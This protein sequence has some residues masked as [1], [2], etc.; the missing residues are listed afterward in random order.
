MKPC[1]R[2]FLH[3]DVILRESN[4]P[5]TCLGSHYDCFSVVTLL[6]PNTKLRAVSQAKAQNPN[7]TPPPPPSPRHRDRGVNRC[8]HSDVSETRRREINC[9]SPAYP[10]VAHPPPPGLPSR[11]KFLPR[12]GPRDPGRRLCPAWQ[13]S[14][15]IYDSVMR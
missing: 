7:N 15:V 12:R 14:C 11:M 3:S 2:C 13:A 8:S 9:K 5:R 1:D 4:P 6:Q 10:G